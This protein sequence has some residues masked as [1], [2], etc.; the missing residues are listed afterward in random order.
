MRRI[1]LTT[2]EQE[3]EKRG[4]AWQDQLLDDPRI[5]TK[6]RRGSLLRKAVVDTLAT[7]RCLGHIRIKESPAVVLVAV[8][9]LAIVSGP[10][11][12]A[13]ISTGT[14]SSNYSR[15][16]KVCVP[17]IAEVSSALRAGVNVRCIGNP[18]GEGA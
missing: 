17:S 14:H 16:D 3:F 7:I 2:K 1:A 18:S 13:T 8:P 12:R 10:S 4:K 15:R 6:S 9:V 5:P 11:G